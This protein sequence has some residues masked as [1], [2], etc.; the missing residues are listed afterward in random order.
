MPMSWNSEAEAKLLLGDF[1][2]LKGVTLD[3]KALAD[4]MGPVPAIKQQ[5]LKL[6]RESGTS[7]AN[8]RGG[9]GADVPFLAR[10]RKRSKPAQSSE[11]PLKK[12]K[13]AYHILDND[14][15]V[16][17]EETKLSIKNEDEVKKLSFVDLA[18]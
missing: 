16:G 5:V 17:E 11:T 1:Q 14:D 13:S 9:S 18:D 8:G 2:Q 15:D 10:T 4:F 12:A 7:V 3:Y 6:R